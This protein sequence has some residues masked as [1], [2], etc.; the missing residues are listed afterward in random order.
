MNKRELVDIT[1][2][3]ACQAAAFLCIILLASIFL[4]LIINSIAFFS[5]KGWQSFFV[6]S[7][8]N[9]GLEQK[10]TY[11]ILP[12]LVSTCMVAFGSMLLAIPLG[13][14]TAAYLSEFAPAWLRAFLK[15]AIELLAAIP[16]VAIGFIA[17]VVTGPALAYWFRLPNGLN[18]IN[19]SILLAIMALPTIISL[20]EEAISAVPQSHREASV[21]LGAH[22]WDTLWRVTLPA[23]SPGLIAAILLGLGRAL[24]ETMTV[25]MATGNSVAMPTQFTDSIRTITATIAIEMGEAP[26]LTQPYYA[27]FVI[28]LVLFAITLMVNLLG[29]YFSQRFKKFE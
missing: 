10:A 4:M 25:L 13:I 16:S 12:L 1:F 17:I 18:A 2:R 19:G 15:P 27:L 21:A 20:S 5:L 22:H 3:W 26:Y 14:F 29:E 8:W 7:H 9:P 23:A 6:S 28:A 24:G 11:G